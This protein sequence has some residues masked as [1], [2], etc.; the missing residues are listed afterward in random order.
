MMDLAMNKADVIEVRPSEIRQARQQRLNVLVSPPDTLVA[1][2]FNNL[3]ID[4]KLR[5]A[6][7]KSVD[8]NSL[9]Q[10]IFQKQGEV[11]AGL[12]PQELCAFNF[13][14]STERNLNVAQAL[15]G[16]LTPPSLSIEADGTEPMQLAAER[17]AL[18]LH[19]GGFN[20]KVVSPGKSGSQQPYADLRLISIALAPGP[21]YAALDQMIHRFNDKSQPVP[22][23][24][25]AEYK[26][27]R[28]FLDQNTLIP[29]LYLPHAWAISERVRD[30]ALTPDGV[31][32]LS[33]VSLESAP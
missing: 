19:D 27:E 18:N 17:L 10:V 9:Q 16:G 5:A 7:A 13:L 2:E 3:S 21:P 15:R 14:F 4:P 1:I 31:P 20:L 12:L 28:E 11:T 24:D 33:S 29:L 25:A 8:R 30:A 23:E 26:S 6:M 32:D 22:E